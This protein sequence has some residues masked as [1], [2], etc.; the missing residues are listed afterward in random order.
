MRPHQA[1]VEIRALI[2]PGSQATFISKTMANTLRLKVA[3]ASTS[4]VGIGNTN[5]G[6]AQHGASLTIYPRYDSDFKLEIYALVL[7]NLTNLLPSED[8]EDQWIHN[9]HL[10]LADPRFN[11][12]GSIDLIIGA[13]YYGDILLPGIMKGAKGTTVAQCTEFGWVVSG[14]AKRSDTPTRATCIIQ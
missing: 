5:A 6:V 7:S 11:K 12:T 3:Q 10:T 1:P 9:K 2:D 14:K 4:V 13:D 8:I